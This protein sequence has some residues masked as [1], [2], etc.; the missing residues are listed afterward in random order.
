MFFIDRDTLLKLNFVNKTRII[1]MINSCLI[2]QSYMKIQSNRINS[3]LINSA[4]SQKRCTLICM[5]RERTVPVDRNSRKRRLKL[6]SNKQKYK[7][8]TLWRDTGLARA[9]TSSSLKVVL[10]SR[11]TSSQSQE[12][13]LRKILS[14][15]SDVQSLV[16]VSRK[17][18]FKNCSLRVALLTR[19]FGFIREKLAK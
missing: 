9:G 1:S 13:F 19:F 10:P 11:T 3:S 7:T 2:Y 6:T 4:V 15:Q 18:N 14:F 12:R 17:F 16:N 8:D 5:L